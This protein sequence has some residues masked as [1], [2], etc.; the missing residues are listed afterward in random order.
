MSRSITSIPSITYLDEND[1]GINEDILHRKEFQIFKKSV[2]AIKF[3]DDLQEKD[4]KNNIIPK[5]LIKNNLP[6]SNYL[7]LRSYQMFVRNYINP[8]TPYSRLF[9]KWQTGL[10]KT[11][12][13]LSLALN[14]IKYYQKQQEL[15]ESNE[16]GS[17]YIIGFTSSIFKEELL[18]FPELGFISRQELEKLEK[19]KKASYSENPVDIENY[20]KYYIAIK[21]R[22]SNRK[23]NGFFKF[24]GYKELANHLFG[25]EDVDVIGITDD[26]ILNM[27]EEGTIKI[28][29]E[30][31]DQFRN[32]LLICDEIHNVYNTYEKNNWGVAIQTILNYHASCRAI[33]LSATPVQNSPTEIIDLLNLLLPRKFYPMLEKKDFFDSKTNAIKNEDKIAEYLQG[34]VSFIIDRNPAF[35]ATKTILGENIKGIDFLKFIRCPMSNFH[36]NTYKEVVVTDISTLG[37]EGQYLLDFV[38]P[39][40]SY[41]E[42]FK[43]IGLYKTKD[44]KTKLENATRVWKTKIGISY[45]TENDIISGNLLKKE[46]IKVISNKYYEMINNIHDDIKN[47]K[48]KIFIYHT[49]IHMS[50]TFFIQE[51]LKHNNIIGEFD[52]SNDDTMCAICGNLRKMHNKNQLNPSISQ[53]NIDHY[54][55][56]VRFMIIHSNLDKSNISKIFDKFNHVNNTDGSKFMILLGSKIIQESR[57]LKAIRNVYVMSKPENMPSFIQIIGRAI[58]L[59]SHSNLPKSQRHV[60]IKIFTSCSPIKKNNIYELGLEEIKY[61]EKTETYKIIQKIEKIIHENAIDAYFNYD[62]IWKKSQDDSKLDM[63][64]YSIDKFKINELNLSTFNAYHSKFEVD[65]IIYMIKRLFIEISSVWKYDDLFSAVKLPPFNTEINTPILSKDSF[66]IALNSIIYSDFQDYIEPQMKKFQNN[67]IN[68]N[69][70]DKIN[71]PDDKIILQKDDVQYVIIQTGSMYSMVPL[72]YNEPSVDTEIIYRSNIST[73]NEIVN[74]IDYLKFYSDFGYEDKKIKFIKKW[75]NTP[76]LYL[77]QSLC[78]F[79][80]KF[81]KNFI[82]DIIVYVFKI[83]TDPKQSKNS[84]HEFYIKMLY[85]YN[86]S[87]IIVWAHTLNEKMSEKYKKYITPVSL[88]LLKESDIELNNLKKTKSQNQKDQNIGTSGT[89][90]LLIETLNKTDPNWISTNLVKDYENKYNTIND[91]FNDIHKKSKTQKIRADLLPVGHNLG[92]IPRFYNPELGIWNDEPSYI[93]KIRVIKEN[94]IIIGYDTRSKTGISIKFKLRSPLKSKS[95]DQRSIEKGSMCSTKSKEFLLNIAKQLHIKFDEQ[96]FATEEICNSIRTRLIYNELKER[97]NK[98]GIKWFYFINEEVSY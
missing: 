8:T 85:Y 66:N 87:R 54:F 59:G 24:I 32:S 63:L 9:L 37:Q 5:F 86:I 71:N 40:P 1:T 51:I 96:N 83:L 56:P 81:H 38:L 53:E 50:G 31:L 84:Y 46:N 68:L 62:T 49:V 45:D 79:G 80:I 35:M 25:L 6:H 48:G 13:S 76:I 41:S 34:R 18:S 67:L 26:K 12:G 44:I 93:D 69:I 61:K 97:L 17:V 73:Q 39:D 98:T 36:Y 90:N 70:L 92:K 47:K 22:L 89:L 7:D 58:R 52:N 94:P 42:P 64:P 14:F 3:K 33:F 91:I 57:S 77:E 74:I 28:N 78:D 19:L 21:K 75:E 65:Y 43:K 10:G 72:E 27:I 88:K 20:K 11:I 55:Q 23:G 15:E 2:E 30:L 16:I 60:D 95:Y 4:E 82:E 29:K